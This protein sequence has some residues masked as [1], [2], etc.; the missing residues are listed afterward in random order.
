MCFRLFL[1]GQFHNMVHTH[2]AVK[3]LAHLYLV[4]IIEMHCPSIYPAV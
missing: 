3:R 4:S 2:L 1:F